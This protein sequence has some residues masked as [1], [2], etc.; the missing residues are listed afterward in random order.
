M[1]NW[2]IR[3]YIAA[4]YPCL[5]CTTNE[6]HRA[7][8]EITEEVKELNEAVQ[9]AQM[10]ELPY[11]IYKWDIA[12][13]LYNLITNELIDQEIKLSN[14]SQPIKPNNIRYPL[15]YLTN[16]E[17]NAIMLLPN[18]HLFL[19]GSNAGNALLIQTI[20]NQSML[21]KVEGKTIVMLS[22][23]YSLPSEIDRLFQL[24]DFPLPNEKQIEKIMENVLP[25]ELANPD[26][27]PKDKK[28][29][30]FFVDF[31]PAAIQAAK[32]MTHYEIENAMS[33]SLIET[34]EK[35]D[36]YRF[37]PTI[38]GEIKK[39]QVKKSAV[40]EISAATHKFE[41]VI[42]MEHLKNYLTKVAMNS[43]AQGIMIVGVQGT[44]KTYIA[45][46]L[47]NE[48]GIPAVTVSFEKIMG[49]GGGIV[50]Q[51]Q[52]QAI[53]TFKTLDAMSPCIAI[54]DEIEKG[55]AGIQSSGRTDSGSKAGVGSIFLKWIEKKS[56]GI[57]IVATSNNVDELPPEYKRAGRWD[58]I[59][60]VDLPNLPE[61]YSNL[62]YYCTK[63]NIED[64][65]SEIDEKM[66]DKFDGYSHA[67]LMTIIKHASMLNCSVEEAKRYVKPILQTDSEAVKKIRDWINQYAILANDK[68]ESIKALRP[69]AAELDIVGKKKLLK[70]IDAKQFIKLNMEN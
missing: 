52:Q 55:L 32:G 1:K 37:D 4:G 17:K 24:T 62:E 23:N 47:A 49:A 48:I 6:A 8:K 59:W 50:G 63:F 58:S 36:E 29:K 22:P 12:S 18:Y 9:E 28:S 11:K 65:F 68:R 61:I 5:F 53:N 35:Y 7:M 41:D 64:K 43:L 10:E 26:Y 60:G 39:Q 51:A 66:L 20:I 69:K 14:E 42:G 44:G 2:I 13:G 15:F 54:M 38:I 46:G 30:K 67:E 45:E 70:K 3:K 16:C 33:L 57:Y 27:N 25:G 31:D 21:W 19:Q 40:L 34:S 56:P